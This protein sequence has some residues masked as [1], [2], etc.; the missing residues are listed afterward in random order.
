MMVDFAEL[1]WAEVV[2]R[3]A[4]VEPTPG[5]GPSLAWTCSLAAALVEMVSAVSLRKQSQHPSAI[6]QRLD[7]AAALREVALSLADTDAAAY[8]EVLSAQRTRHEPGHGER[9]RQ[10]LLAAADP[11]VAIVEAAGEVTRLAAEAAAE[12]RGGVRGEAM[13]AA[14]LGAAVVQAGVPLIELNL[15]GARDDPRLARVR[16]LGEEADSDRV[17]ALTGVNRRS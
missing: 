8:R 13:T 6:V 10:A 4:S 11:L 2:Q 12:A 16:Y 1:P 5:A 14:V 15:A 7:R 17:R 3:V 9:L